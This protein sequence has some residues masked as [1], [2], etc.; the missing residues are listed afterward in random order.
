MC[1]LHIMTILFRQ[2]HLLWLS[3]ILC[4]KLELII[5]LSWRRKLAREVLPFQLQSEICNRGKYTLKHLQSH[6]L[7]FH[8]H[9]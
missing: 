6:K 9:K 4:E 5:K 7:Q 2:T 3:P 1:N 8:I